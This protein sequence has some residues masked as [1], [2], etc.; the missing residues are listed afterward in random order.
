MRLLYW[1]LD[2][3][4]G[5]RETLFGGV[6][7]TPE[8]LKAMK[9]YKKLHPRCEISGSLKAVEPHHKKPV[10]L[11]PELAADPHNFISLSTDV[12]GCN[13]HLLFG[14][15]GNY[16]KENLD[17]EEDASIWRQKLKNG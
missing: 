16:K 11:H 1:I 3:W 6:S 8:C 2:W 13:L 5:N 15:K 10:H 14:H 9:E 17:I 7:R 4:R 12:F